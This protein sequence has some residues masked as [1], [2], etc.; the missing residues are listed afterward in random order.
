MFVLTYNDVVFLGPMKWHPRMFTSVIKDDYDLDVTIPVTNPYNVRVDVT[1][2]IV[3]RPVE[4]DPEPTF[5]PKIERLAGP[6]WT[7]Q[8]DKV[9]GNY[10]VED[11]PIEAV[12][13]QLKTIV[14]DN[15]W[16]K[17]VGGI[18][19][20][21][22]GQD[23]SVITERGDRDMYMQ[24]YQLGVDTVGW[25]FIDKWLTLS[26]AELGTITSTVLAHV[27]SQFDWE[28]SKVTEIDNCT[29]LAQLDAVI[30]EPGAGSPAV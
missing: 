2:E 11:L 22:Q 8:V 4:F 26:N 1:P 15:R 5:N 28:G 20:N 9:V 14:T 13:N 6:F 30:L 18:T 7:M 16:K 21:I 19:M 24:A 29:T 10:T 25:K 17:E 3:I 12:K 23:V 27:Q